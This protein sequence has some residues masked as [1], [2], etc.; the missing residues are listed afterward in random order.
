MLG[1]QSLPD[2]TKLFK[3]DG[4]VDF[5]VD[6]LVAGVANMVM[7]VDNSGTGWLRLPYWCLDGGALQYSLQEVTLDTGL[8]TLSQTW[9][10]ATE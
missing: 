2:Q 1:I 3:T 8:W 4:V 10:D 7:E 9:A 6:N 5:G